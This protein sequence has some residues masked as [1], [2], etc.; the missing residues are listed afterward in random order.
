MSS[1]PCPK[2]ETTRYLGRLAPYFERRCRRSLDALGVEHAADDVVAHA[3][4]VLHAAAADQHHRVLLQV[5]ALARDVARH[6]DPVGQAD[7]R[8]LAQRRV[9]LLRRRRVDARA[10]AALLRA[11]LHR[12]YLVPLSGLSPRLADE[13]LYRRHR[14]LYVQSSYGQ[15]PIPS[16]AERSGVFPRF[17][18]SIQ[19]TSGG[20]ILQD[21]APEV[22]PG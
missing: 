21:H 20:P 3:G 16:G 15:Q 9:R 2:H 12:R 18:A 11:G 14:C 10:D 8:H 7:A 6:L 19:R 22:S 5:V 17:G 4:Q 1:Y 13:L